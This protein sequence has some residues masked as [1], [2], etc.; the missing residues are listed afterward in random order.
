M[1]VHFV[2]NEWTLISFVAFDLF[3]YSLD[4]TAWFN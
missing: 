3:H 1:G 4:F 2:H